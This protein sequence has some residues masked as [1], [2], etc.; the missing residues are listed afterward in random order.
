MVRIK[1]HTQLQLKRFANSLVTPIVW[2]KN[3]HYSV[4]FDPNLG[5]IA[6]VTSLQAPDAVPE[7]FLEDFLTYNTRGAGAYLFLP[8]G[9]ASSFSNGEK[10]NFMRVVKGP[11]VET[12]LPKYVSRTVTLYSLSGNMLFSPTNSQVVAH[13]FNDR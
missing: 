8:V 3:E 7:Y 1:Y 9:P 12:T 4:H 6:Q 2:I 11:L 13:I 10:G 5:T